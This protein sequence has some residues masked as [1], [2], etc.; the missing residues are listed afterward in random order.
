MATSCA[1]SLKQQKEEKKSAAEW[2]GGVGWWGA[3]DGSKAAF[4]GGNSW[5]SDFRALPSSLYS[6]LVLVQSLS[7]QC[8]CSFVNPPPPPTPYTS[9][10]CCLSPQKSPVCHMRPAGMH[11][12]TGGKIIFVYLD[13]WTHMITA[14]LYIT[15]A[16]LSVCVDS[17]P[18]RNLPEFGHHCSDAAMGGLLFEEENPC[19]AQRSG[20]YRGITAHCVC[21]CVCVLWYVPVCMKKQKSQKCPPCQDKVNS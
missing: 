2:F 17:N 12:T 20:M 15:L 11:M 4:M 3:H 8:L 10:I 21:V 16:T 18:H 7:A 13:V 5:T 1:A 19:S 14:C 6:S 9:L